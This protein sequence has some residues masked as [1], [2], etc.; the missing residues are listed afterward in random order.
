LLGKKIALVMALAIAASM[1]LAGTALAK[2]R[3]HDRIPDRWEKAHHLSL[4]VKQGGRDQ[5][6]DGLK[7]RGE[8]RAKLNPRDSDTDNDGVEDGDEDAGTVASFD[9]TT[10]TIALAKGG[11]LSAKVTDQTEVEC[12]DDAGD[13]RGTDGART[14]SD[15]PGDDGDGEHGDG[16]GDNGDDDGPDDAA[17]DDGEHDDHGGDSQNEDC[18]PEALVAGTK[19]LEA[20]LKVI[21]GEAVW[22]S[23][24]VLKP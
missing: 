10:L 6:K 14:S 17:N 15:D 9:G 8:W 5:D 18:G 13:D 22:S 11:T 7:N 2:D 20:E 16:P 19:V 23:V 4:K 1:A 12:D 3:N 24:E 21:G